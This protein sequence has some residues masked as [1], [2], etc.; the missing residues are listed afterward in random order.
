MKNNVKKY[1]FSSQKCVFLQI[2]HVMNALKIFAT[3]DCMSERER[4][5]R[6]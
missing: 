3:I 5:K 2:S 4:R 6:K 1:F